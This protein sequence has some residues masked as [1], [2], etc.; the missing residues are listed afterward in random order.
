MPKNQPWKPYIG[1]SVNIFVSHPKKWEYDKC[2][3]CVEYFPC[4][5]IQRRWYQEKCRIKKQQSSTSDH[6]K[7]IRFLRPASYPI[8]SYQTEYESHQVSYTINLGESFPLLQYNKIRNK[9]SKHE[10]RKRNR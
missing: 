8:N 7:R 4:H 5:I 10:I 1:N 6:Q 2:N 9:R 3:S